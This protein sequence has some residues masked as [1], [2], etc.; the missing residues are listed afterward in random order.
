[1]RDLERLPRPVIVPLPAEIDIAN[2]DDVGVRLRAAFAPRVAVVIAD[3]GLTV[4]CDCAG[5]RHLLL[6]HDTAAATGAELRLVVQ[7]GCVRRILAVL[8]ADRV[9]RVYPSLGA[10][11]MAGPAPEA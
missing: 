3:L 4:F 10:A 6:A 7:S 8:G 2:G 9:L 11:L 5:V 1:M